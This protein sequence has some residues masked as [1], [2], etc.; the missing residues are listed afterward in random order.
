MIFKKALCALLAVAMLLCCVPVMAE[1]A[2]IYYVNAPEDNTEYDTSVFEGHPT[3]LL[4]DDFYHSQGGNI[5]DQSKVKPSGWDI[6][7]RGGSVTKAQHYDIGMGVWDFSETEQI[8]MSKNLLPH[9][10]GKITFEAGFTMMIQPKSGFSYELLGNGK[11]AAQFITKDDTVQLVQANG[12]NITIGKYIVDKDFAI[13]AELDLDRGKVKVYTQGKYIG[14]FD[15]TED[16]Q[17]IDQIVVST[18][19]EGTVDVKLKFIY[20]YINYLVNEVFLQ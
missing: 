19:K 1:E 9:K 16:C 10:S 5:P 8:R 3:Y 12:K 6:D 4:E 14:D 13:K 2:P 20:L 18:P 11:V 7:Y 15:F 17:Q